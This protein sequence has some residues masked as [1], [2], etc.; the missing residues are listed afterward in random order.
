M[1][2]LGITYDAHN[3]P[4]FDESFIPFGVWAQAYLSDAQ[5][6]VTISIERE[7]G[8]VSTFATA[9]RD[10]TFADANYRFLERVVKFLI[11]SRGGFCVRI[12]GADELVPL[13]SKAYSPAGERAFDAAFMETLYGEPLRMVAVLKET[14]PNTHEHAHHIGGHTNGCRIG[15][16]AGGSNK[17]VAAVINGETVFTEETPWLPKQHN[18]P[19]YHY[20]EVLKSLVSAASHLPRVDAVGISSAGTFVGNALKTS[21]LFINV[22]PA[23]LQDA[24]SIYER[25]C[26]EIG[27][28]TFA[29]VNDGDA[30]ALAGY[31]ASG[32]GNILGIS[33]GTSEA[34]GY[35]NESG[36]VLGWINEL[37]FAPVDLSPT[38]AVDDWSGDK[39]VGCSYLSQDA[40][41]KLAKVAG[42]SLPLDATPAEQQ[43]AVQALANDGNEVALQIYK[44]IGSYLA[45]TL[46]LYNMF[47]QIDTVLVLGGVASG[48]GGDALM[49]ECNRILSEDY[50]DLFFSVNVCFPN[51]EM[52]VIGQSVAAA[53]LP[54]LA[55]VTQ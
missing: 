32:K 25:A 10:T 40:V 5:R 31:L 39:G 35:V 36:S 51:E 13:L 7:D 17:K 21:S 45:H 52:R 8:L 15:F 18:T 34:A 22:D 24:C 2:Y 23:H 16:D 46:V 12:S 33:L 26:L 55:A 48:A 47:Y 19:D 20:E 28:E 27:A 11:W 1:E 4:V 6:A 44:S 29:A 42:L 38:A 14:L 30:T 3:E 49:L 50:P 43:L 9:L 41:I 54:A 37:A 53:S